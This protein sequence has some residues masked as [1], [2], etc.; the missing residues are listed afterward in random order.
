MDEK[1]TTN[2][3]VSEIMQKI[4]E[5]A[6]QQKG[7]IKEQAGYSGGLVL[8]AVKPATVAVS[9][10]PDEGFKALIS[11]EPPATQV[12]TSISV[13]VLIKVKNM[14]PVVWPCK[15]NDGRY[16][17]NLSYHWY[18]ND[19]NFIFEGL[20]T[21]LPCDAQPYEEILVNAVVKPPY[22][23]GEYVL[24][25]DMVQDGVSWFQKK[26]SAVSRITVPV[27]RIIT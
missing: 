9:P 3:D 23:S 15:S 22:L 19:E 27:A 5:A 1:N 6:A 26:G 8:N 13:N 4:K 11:I 17:I 21:Q 24:E 18:K 7:L 12:T 25:F 16:Q 20:R 10:L 2:D 14:S